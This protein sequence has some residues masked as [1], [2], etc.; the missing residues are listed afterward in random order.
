VKVLR[1]K[2]ALHPEGSDRGTPY[3]VRICIKTKTIFF[4]VISCDDPGYRS[5]AVEWEYFAW[6]YLSGM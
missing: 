2:G 4:F 1:S 6:L 3:P 5:L